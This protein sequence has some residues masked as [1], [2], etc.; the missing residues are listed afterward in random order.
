MSLLLVDSIVKA[1]VS[2]DLSVNL[3]RLDRASAHGVNNALRV[4][5]LPVIVRFLGQ[6]R[7]TILTFTISDD[8]L[9]YEVVLGSQWDLWCSEH[10]GEL[11]VK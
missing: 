6:G 2:P 5:D 4:V 9:A 1:A 3:L 8:H 7:T 11:F 10:K